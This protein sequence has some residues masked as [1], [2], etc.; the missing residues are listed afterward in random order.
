MRQNTTQRARYSAFS[1]RAQ[2]AVI[3]IGIIPLISCALL[4]KSEGFGAKLRNGGNF[5]GCNPSISPDGR[6][7]AFAGLSYDPAG[8]FP[9]FSDHGDS[10]DIY[11]MNVDGT[12]LRR[13]TKYCG[14]DGMPSFSKDGK[15][16]VYISEDGSYSGRETI[17]T[18]NADGTAP[19]QLTHGNRF[20]DQVAIS[21]RFRDQEPFFAPSGERICFSRRGPA[22]MSGYPAGRSE[23]HYLEIWEDATFIFTISA[24]GSDETLVTTGTGVWDA[25]ACDYSPD[26]KS[27]LFNVSGKLWLMDAGGDNK[28]PIA[29]LAQFSCSDAK[30]SPDGKEI[31]LSDMS[32][33]IHIWNNIEHRLE[34]IPPP[35][36]LSFRG[37]Q[38]HYPVFFPD[39]RRLLILATRHAGL[40]RG[41]GSMWV[42]DRDTHRWRELGPTYGLDSGSHS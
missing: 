15:K 23:L 35:F 5:M 8:G 37:A 21:G 31:I 4:P 11:S 39:G 29:D 12:G 25:S 34:H 3:A 32:H 38:V 1:V 42:Y 18:M 6:T 28:R 27:I 14:Y 7:V 40:H 36:D 19:R 16:I 22:D 30:F 17:W 10:G 41:M 13:L 2:V 9:S 24:S 20:S 33:G 26:G